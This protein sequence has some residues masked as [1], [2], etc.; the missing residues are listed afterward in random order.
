MSTQIDPE[1]PTQVRLVDEVDDG[2]DTQI[3]PEA[4]TQVCYKIPI[5]AEI[6]CNM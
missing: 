5:H 1:A 4:P 6:R 2:D 3:D